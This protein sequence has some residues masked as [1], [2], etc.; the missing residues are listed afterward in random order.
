MSVR[1]VLYLT[2]NLSFNPDSQIFA[3]RAGNPN[4]RGWNATTRAVAQLHNLVLA[5]LSKKGDDLSEML[6]NIPLG[7]EQKPENQP[8]APTLRELSAASMAKFMS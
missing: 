4:A 8:V 2:H 6:L 1:H 3:V 7:E 5:A